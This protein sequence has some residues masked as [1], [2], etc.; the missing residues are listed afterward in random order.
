M[1]PSFNGSGAPNWETGAINA[2][3]TGVLLLGLALLDLQQHS[4]R[5]DSYQIVLGVWLCASPYLLGYENADLG[6]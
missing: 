1:S 2:A 6:S 3:L 4:Q 5:T